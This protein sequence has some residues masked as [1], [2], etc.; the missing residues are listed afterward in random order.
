MRARRLGRLAGSWSARLQWLAAAWRVWGGG[1]PLFVKE[2]RTQWRGSRVLLL[3]GLSVSLSA[4]A[5]SLLFLLSGWVRLQPWV[6]E[7]AV[8]SSQALFLLF[9]AAVFA[10]DVF[11]GEKQDGTLEFLLLTPMSSREILLG[12]FTGT[13]WPFLLAALAHL[14]LLTLLCQ[15][16]AVPPL[17]ALAIYAVLLPATVVSCL[18]AV[19]RGLVWGRPDALL[20]CALPLAAGLMAAV[21]GWALLQCLR[22]LPSG[23]GWLFATTP[24]LAVRSGWLAA[25]VGGAVGYFA[26]GVPLALISLHRASLVLD[27]AGEDLLAE[28]TSALGLPY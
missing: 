17:R 7:L 8:F 9:L 10:A 14:P 11:A 23:A 13:L 12:K 19:G 6:A 5:V 1:N 16:G 21:S 26:L 22:L 24:L 4:L 20:G 2:M 27:A 25:L 28:R 15:V 3:P 18:I